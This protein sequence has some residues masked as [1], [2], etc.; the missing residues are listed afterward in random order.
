MTTSPLLIEVDACPRGANGASAEGVILRPSAGKQWCFTYNNPMGAT[1]A[2][3]ERHVNTIHKSFRDRLERADCNYIFQYEVGESGTP[4][5]QGFVQFES[6]K[7]PMS[8]F[9]DY[10][11]IHWEKAKGTVSEN[12]KYC[13]KGEG[14]LAGPW[15]KGLLPHRDVHTISLGQMHPWQKALLEKL[16]TECSQTDRKIHWYWDPTG[17]IGKSAL[18][19]YLCVHNMALI[20]SGKGTDILYGLK[21]FKDIHGA[22]PPILVIDIPRCTDVKFVSYQAIE[23]C[24]NGC[25]YS[26]KYEGSMLLMPP[27][28]IV[29]FSNEPPDLSTFSADRWNVV[30]LNGLLRP[31]A[32]RPVRP[33]P[34]AT[35]PNYTFPTS[36]DPDFIQQLDTLQEALEVDYEELEESLNNII[37]PGY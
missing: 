3:S 8:I 11:G 15:Y 25:A 17:N 20:A 36:P 24:K 14:R 12:T 30:E 28:H 19:K 9:S 37:A 10:T 32:F 33:S 5:Y 1:G 4:H 26:G 31:E 27:M 6:R 22:F 21:T 7:R 2:Q 18:A 16:T 29:I 35:A 23:S 34:G 13:S